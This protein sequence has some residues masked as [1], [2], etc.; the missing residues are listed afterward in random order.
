MM[1][2]LLQACEAWLQFKMD[3]GTANIGLSNDAQPP[4]TVDDYFIAIYGTSCVP[5]DK[6]WNQ[7][8]DMICDI[9]ITISKRTR[10]NPLDLTRRSELLADTANISTML[11]KCVA[12]LHLEHEVLSRANV[13]IQKVGGNTDGFVEPLR[14]L[15][16]DA[17]PKYEDESWF[18]PEMSKDSPRRDAT[19]PKA[20]II[21][22]ASLGEARRPMKL[23]TLRSEALR[24]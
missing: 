13:I 12:L 21:L 14:F 4:R 17:N 20:G 16:M 18:V 5:G 11:W 1:P 8:I 19:Y 24:L 6:D 2:A 22:E 7:G 15:T 23:T 3:M 10:Y 9:G